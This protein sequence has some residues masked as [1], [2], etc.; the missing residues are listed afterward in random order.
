MVRG[1]LSAKCE[2]RDVVSVWELTKWKRGL[3]R[4]GRFEQG[5]GKE[6]QEKIL[7]G[8]QCGQGVKVCRFGYAQG[9]RLM[10][11]LQSR[12]GWWKL[13]ECIVPEKHT[14]TLKEKSKGL[15]LNN[16]RVE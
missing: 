3:Q 13:E 15:G 7:F 6:T 8:C 12:S 5:N 14:C 16:E 4:D 1:A 9:Q 10:L 2:G 11:V